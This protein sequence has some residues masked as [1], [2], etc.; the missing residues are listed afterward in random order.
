MQRMP[1][2]GQ[3]RCEKVVTKIYMNSL[4]IATISIQRMMPKVTQQRLSTLKALKIPRTLTTDYSIVSLQLMK[5][6]LKRKMGLV[7]YPKSLLK[8]LSMCQDFQFHIRIH[9]VHAQ[10]CR[11][12]LPWSMTA[13]R[14][15]RAFLDRCYKTPHLRSDPYPYLPLLPSARPE[16]TSDDPTYSHV[17]QRRRVIGTDRL[18]CLRHDSCQLSRV[19]VNA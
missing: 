5:R 15:S 12:S 8:P 6:L 3:R 16:A 4:A 19:T 2:I 14:P 9:L 13:S 7:T 17:T 11:L 1:E 18:A 10:P